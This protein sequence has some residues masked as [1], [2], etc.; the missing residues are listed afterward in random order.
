M[1]LSLSPRAATTTTASRG[2]RLPLAIGAGPLPPPSA[3]PSP[4]PFAAAIAQTHQPTHPPT[5]N[6]GRHHH[7]RHPPCCHP[8]Q[9][10]NISLQL[11][12]LLDKAAASQQHVADTNWQLTCTHTL[13]RDSNFLYGSGQQS[14]KRALLTSKYSGAARVCLSACAGAPRPPPLRLSPTGAQ[15]SH[16]ASGTPFGSSVGRLR[17][18]AS[19]SRRG[20]TARFQ[21]P[22]RL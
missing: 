15:G 20:A 6:T 8:Q 4:P 18:P 10:T 1:P 13:C 2:R 17:E 19:I 16:S 7:P 3:P 12:Q 14:N 21:Y 11:Q 5:P 22:Q 9:Q